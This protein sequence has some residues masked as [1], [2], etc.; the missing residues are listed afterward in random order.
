MLRRRLKI[1]DGFKYQTKESQLK[2]YQDVKDS[3]D[4]EYRFKQISAIIL[5]DKLIKVDGTEV[6]VTSNSLVQETVE[7]VSIDV[8]EKE[9]HSL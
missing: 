5:D 2:Y 7:I 4:D 1:I 6:S 9:S 8:E 3:T